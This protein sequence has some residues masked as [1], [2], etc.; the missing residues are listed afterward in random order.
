[1]FRTSMN[2]YVQIN[3]Q[4]TGGVINNLPFIIIPP[5]LEDRMGGCLGDCLG[6]CLGDRLGDCSGDCLEDC[7]GDDLDDSFGDHPS[8]VGAAEGRP[9]R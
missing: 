1:M 8:S 4:N 5:P 7:L 6:N 9:H 3:F 2:R